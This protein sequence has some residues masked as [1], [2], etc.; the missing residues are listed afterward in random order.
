VNGDAL[1]TRLMIPRSLLQ[2][3]GVEV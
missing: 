1:G 3:L 2:S